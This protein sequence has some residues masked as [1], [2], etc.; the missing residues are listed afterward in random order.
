MSEGFFEQLSAERIETLL[1]FGVQQLPTIRDSRQT[2]NPTAR[3]RV[4]D[5]LE[6]QLLGASGREV[7]FSLIN[8]WFQNSIEGKDSSSNDMAMQSDPSTAKKT[9][10]SKR[11]ALNSTTNEIEIAKLEVQA[12]LAYMYFAAILQLGITGRRQ[13]FCGA[14]QL[15]CSEYDRLSGLNPP[16]AKVWLKLFEAGVRE[17]SLGFDPR[18][19]QL[20]ENPLVMWID[21]RGMSKKVL[22]DL[23]GSA[24]NGIREAFEQTK[25]WGSWA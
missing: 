13:D 22:L 23:L 11:N 10:C 25:S 16:Q 14:L 19:E 4:L 12:P 15:A 6:T 5:D 3:Q 2:R 1:S 9:T 18:A 24:S 21:P 20:P 7:A 17:W 8:Q